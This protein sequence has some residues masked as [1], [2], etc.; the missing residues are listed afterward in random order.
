MFTD[1]VILGINRE[2]Q[3]SQGDTQAG[4]G[5]GHGPHNTIENTLCLLGLETCTVDPAVPFIV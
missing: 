1:A 5:Q 2:T 3:Q 4:E